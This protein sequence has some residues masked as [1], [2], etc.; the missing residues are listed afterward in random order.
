LSGTILLVDD[1]PDFAALTSHH[2]TKGGL[3]VVI[4]DRGARAL[5]LIE[6]EEFDLVLTEIEMPG[7]DGLTVMQT[8]RQRGVSI[9]IVAMSANGSHEMRQKCLDGGCNEFLAKPIDRQQL[10]DVIRCHLAPA[11]PIASRYAD[12]PEMADFIREFVTGLPVRIRQMQTE[13]QSGDAKPLVSLARQL[14]SIASGSG[15]CGFDEI[16]DAAAAVEEALN[17]T[18]DWKAAEAAMSK[19]ADMARRAKSTPSES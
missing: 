18:P 4:A 14:K 9:P 16:S 7:M 3:K 5:E 10:V 2:L 12:N 15:G 19:L 6:E 1:A 17:Q 8:M 11:E 13:L